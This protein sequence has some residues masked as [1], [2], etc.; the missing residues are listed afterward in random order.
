[1]QFPG[2]T[3]MQTPQMA[4]Q[5]SLGEVGLSIL[6]AAMQRQQQQ[7]QAQAQ[8]G[9]PAAP[10]AGQQPAFGGRS[11]LIQMA[12]G[13]LLNGLL[14]ALF[15]GGQGGQ[16]PAQKQPGAPMQIAPMLPGGVAMGQATDPTVL[17]GLW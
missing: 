13:G 11:P 7:P 14:P 6:R 17:S 4:Q 8:G 5:P 9:V 15:G 12:Q 10:A 1:M 2:M 3:P 16:Q